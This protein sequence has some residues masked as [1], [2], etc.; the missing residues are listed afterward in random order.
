MADETKHQQ[1]PQDIDEIYNWLP[2]IIN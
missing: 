1:T 2:V